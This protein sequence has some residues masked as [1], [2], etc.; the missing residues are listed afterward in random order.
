MAV[1]TEPTATTI[2]TEAWKAAG[3]L[4]PTSAQLTRATDEWLQEVFNDIW[5]K[6][7]ENGNTRLKTLQETLIDVSTLHVRTYALA[8]DMDEEVI[9]E[10]LD[11]SRYATA[12]DGASTTL[13]LAAADT[14]T[15]ANTEG[16]WVLITS[17]TGVDEIK[18]ITDFNTTTKVA[19]VE[20][21]WTATPTSSSTYLIVD[22][23]YQLEEIDMSEMSTGSPTSGRPTAFAK[24]NRQLIFDRPWDRATYGI[25]IRYFMNLHEV[26]LTTGATTRI[27][28][29]YQNWQDV[30]KQGVLWKVMRAIDD[31]RYLAEKQIYEDKVRMLL[32]KEISYGG[33][34]QGFRV[35]ATPAKPIGSLSTRAACTMT[36]T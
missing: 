8:E 9:V 27:T 6:S 23:E 11:G 26:N 1:P 31:N 25:R 15:E 36:G 17:G 20:S 34:F 33:S 22:N 4:S 24:Y 30:L 21:A 32:A 2:V 7:A 16:R 12:Q 35:W 14:G 5:L 10:V 18:Q 19:T 13:T 29:I 28:R 3:Q